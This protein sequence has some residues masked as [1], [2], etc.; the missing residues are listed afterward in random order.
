MNDE[1]VIELLKL[2][3][4]R[5]EILR[6]EIAELKRQIDELEIA[7]APIKVDGGAHGPIGECNTT[8]SGC[9]RFGWPG[10]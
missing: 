1:D 4:D 10:G 7:Y 6:R 2:K 8:W 5:I 3:D 9:S